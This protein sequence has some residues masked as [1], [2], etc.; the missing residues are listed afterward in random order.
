ILNRINGN[1]LLL[2][3]YASHGLNTEELSSDLDQRFHYVLNNL[4]T[5]SLGVGQ[6][7]SIFSKPIELT[8]VRQ[9]SGL[10][11]E[12]IDDCLAELTSCALIHLDNGSISFRHDG[13]RQRLYRTLTGGKRIALHTSAYILFKEKGAT[14]EL[15]ADHAFRSRTYKDAALL[16]VQ[17]G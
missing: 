10:T 6:L 15:L 4:T 9:L 12:E 17:V 1:P 11:D 2:H 8:T 16:C 5:R 3:E 7:V 13:F 14:T